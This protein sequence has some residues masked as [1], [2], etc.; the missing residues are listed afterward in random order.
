MADKKQ[1]D[2]NNL[3]VA[4]AIGL[5]HS[6]DEAFDY[7][8]EVFAPGSAEE[9]QSIVIVKELEEKR[10][11]HCVLHKIKVLGETATITDYFSKHTSTKDNEAIFEI[12]DPKFVE[13]ILEHLRSAQKQRNSGAPTVVAD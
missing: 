2:P 3:N 4:I 10:K 7:N 11:D 9:E 1:V 5:F 8:L 13:N 6:L 12:K